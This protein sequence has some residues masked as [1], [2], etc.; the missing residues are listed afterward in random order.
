VPALL[1]LLEEPEV[2]LTVLLSLLLLDEE[3]VDL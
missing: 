3:E 1:F 2:D